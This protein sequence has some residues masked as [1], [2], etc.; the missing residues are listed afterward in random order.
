MSD[1]TAENKTGPLPKK[2]TA[3]PANGGYPV[4]EAEL[5]SQ[6]A[7]L[8]KAAAAGAHALKSPLSSVQSRTPLP[9]SAPT[10]NAQTQPGGLVQASALSKDVP[11]VGQAPSPD[12]VTV[13]RTSDVQVNDLEPI[14]VEMRK[15]SALADTQR[16]LNKWLLIFIVV[17]IPALLGLGVLMAQRLKRPVESD[18]ANHKTSWSDVDDSA[19]FGDFEKAIA[20]GEELIQ[21]TPQSPEAHQRLAGA[22][23]AAGKLDKAK[24]HY[25]EAFRLFP[26]EENQQLL[27]AIEKRINAE[28]P[29]A[30]T[31]Q[32]DISNDATNAVSQ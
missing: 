1:S 20:L 22:Y 9:A 3:K 27:S 11:N 16:K 21:K 10:Q 12:T 26:S 15:L 29:P 19:R 2:A 24:E 25:A 13:A 4:D 14:L 28:T 7:R 23:V 8:R 32:K 31:P 17:L 6:Q 30:A 5:A 18:P